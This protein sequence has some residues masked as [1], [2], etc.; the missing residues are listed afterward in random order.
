M[1]SP[2][3]SSMGHWRFKSYTQPY[4][5]DTFSC[6]IFACATSRSEVMKIPP[7]GVASSFSFTG[8]HWISETS[9]VLKAYKKIKFHQQMFM[10]VFDCEAI[11]YVR[12]SNM[13][14]RRGKI[15]VYFSI[16]M[17]VMW[18]FVDV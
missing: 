4:K 5:Y 12:A 18:T 2:L 14:N 17:W 13:Y 16:A 6:V 1:H 7:I 11:S 8:I 9:L 15:P 3:G 10:Y